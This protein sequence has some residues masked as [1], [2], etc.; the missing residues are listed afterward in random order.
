[1]FAPQKNKQLGKCYSLN[2]I[3]KKTDEKKRIANVLYKTVIDN[4]NITSQNIR[5]AEEVSN[6]MNKTKLVEENKVKAF[7]SKMSLLA[8]DIKEKEKE[9]Q[10]SKVL[11]KRKR[12]E[13]LKNSLVLPNLPGREAE[14]GDSVSYDSIIPMNFAMKQLI[15]NNPF[16]QK[17]QNLNGSGEKITIDS[18]YD[19]KFRTDTNNFFDQEKLKKQQKIIRQKKYKDD[20]EEQ[21]K[22]KLEKI[23]ENERKEK[24]IEQKMLIHT[25]VPYNKETNKEYIKE[26]DMILHDKIRQKLMD[27]KNEKSLDKE[28]GT[29]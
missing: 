29:N 13:L 25:E 14:K 12:E 4:F 24:E 9:L 11:K 7:I 18:Y 22:E 17:E 23:A 8:H 15:K 6:F 2:N 10:L 3:S 26:L 20:L 21:I 5:I 1:M 19:S 16:L 28:I 27:Y